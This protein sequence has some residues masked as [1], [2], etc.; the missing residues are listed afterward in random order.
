MAGVETGPIDIAKYKC[1]P[2]DLL[3]NVSDGDQ[4]QFTVNEKS[5]SLKDFKAQGQEAQA[6]AG[7]LAGNDTIDADTIENII[8]WMF[9]A[10]AVLFGVVV[11][12]YFGLSLS[13]G[14]ATIGLPSTLRGLPVIMIASLLFAVLGFLAGYFLR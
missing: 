6:A 7:A 8:I 5:T 9:V 4:V 11:L 12:F 14:N 1:V 10:F 3:R 13:S 2:L